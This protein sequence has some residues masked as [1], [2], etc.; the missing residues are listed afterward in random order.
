V[1]K[2]HK[3]VIWKKQGLRWTLTDAVFKLQNN[4]LMDDFGESWTLTDA[5]FKY[6]TPIVANPS[7]HVEP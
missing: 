5:V 1:F 2:L 7:I 3:K 6:T 4:Y